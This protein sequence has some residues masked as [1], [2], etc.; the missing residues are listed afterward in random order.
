MDIVG[1]MSAN[2]PMAVVA[3]IVIGLFRNILGWLENA[4]KD[5]KIDEYEWKQLFRTVTKY[6][7]YVMILMVGLPV[8]Q[9]ITAAFGLDIL[10]SSLE[11]I[12]VKQP[13][14]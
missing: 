2:I 13:E 1:S 8:D 6:F 5:G 12:A 11:K 4:L 14:V 10:K 3:A 9:A 7:T